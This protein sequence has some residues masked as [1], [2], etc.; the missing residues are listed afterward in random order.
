MKKKIS[1]ELLHETLLS[2]H[3]EENWRAVV[4]QQQSRMA[5]ELE[6]LAKFLDRPETYAPSGSKSPKSPSTGGR[7]SIRKDVLS[8]QPFVVAIYDYEANSED[9]LSFFV[10]DKIKVLEMTDEWWS[11]VRED[12]TEGSFPSNYVTFVDENDKL[13]PTSPKVGPDAPAVS[14]RPSRAVSF[15]LGGNDTFDLQEKKDK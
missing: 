13:S 7:S 4:L 3:N 9:E 2:T 12:G 1:S 15:R 5:S 8:K 6:A 10:G 14:P 11:G